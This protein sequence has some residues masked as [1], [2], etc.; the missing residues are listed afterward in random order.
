MAAT[1]ISVHPAH[2]RLLSGL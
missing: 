2:Q 1:L